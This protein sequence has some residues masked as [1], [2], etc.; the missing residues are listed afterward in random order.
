[1]TAKEGIRASLRPIRGDVKKNPSFSSPRETDV[2]PC[3]QPHLS[4]GEAVG[5]P[6]VPDRPSSLRFVLDGFMT[7]WSFDAFGSGSY[8]SKRVAFRGQHGPI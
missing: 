1:M 6:H 8:A 5:S 2:V 7:P 3:I 4:S